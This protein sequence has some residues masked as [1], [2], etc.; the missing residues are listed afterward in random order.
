MGNSYLQLESGLVIPQQGAGW[1]TVQAALKQH[2]Q[3][4]ELGQVKGVWKVYFR[5]SPDM[6]P[7]FLCD[8]R[9]PDGSPRELSMG[10][11]DKVRQLDRNSREKAPTEDDLERQRQKNLAKHRADLGEAIVEDTTPK[12]GRALVPPLTTWKQK[13]WRDREWEKMQRRRR[14]GLDY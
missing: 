13:R 3:H 14:R 1:A 6:P 5:A 8:W 9:D 10:L 7:E 2:D 12:H 11:V 4:L